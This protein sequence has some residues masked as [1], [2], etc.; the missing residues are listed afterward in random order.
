MV[1]KI[2]LWFEKLFPPE[3]RLVFLIF[4]ISLILASGAIWFSIVAHWYRTPVPQIVETQ[5]AEAL[6]ALPTQTLRPFPTMTQTPARRLH[7]TR[8]PK[9]SP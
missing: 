3:E 2:S 6:T 7:P 1:A 8:T 9:F 5:I 4:L